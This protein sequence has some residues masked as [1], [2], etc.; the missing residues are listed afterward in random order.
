LPYGQRLIADVLN[1]TDTAMRQEHCFLA[2][3]LALKAEAL[4]TRVE[5]DK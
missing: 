3:E 2:T 5:L 1:R 4:A